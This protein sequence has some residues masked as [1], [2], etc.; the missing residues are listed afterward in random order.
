MIAAKDALS[1]G[2]R[3]FKM[4][5]VSPREIELL[6]IPGSPDTKLRVEDVQPLIDRFISP[7]IQA[8]PVLVDKIEPGPG[9]KYIMHESRCVL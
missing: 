3:K 2:V 6:Y 8:R 4:I 7:L 9:G 5:Q 1:L